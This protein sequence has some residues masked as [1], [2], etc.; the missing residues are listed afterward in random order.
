M[1]RLAVVQIAVAAVALTGALI[2]LGWWLAAADTDSPPQ[3]AEVVDLRTEHA[4]N[5]IGVEHD[6]PRLAWRLRS[7]R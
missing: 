7:D 4:R 2:G 6:S 5:P 1:R 3:P